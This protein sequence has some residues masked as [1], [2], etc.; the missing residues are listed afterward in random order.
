MLLKPPTP[1]LQVARYVL[2]GAC[3]PPVQLTLPLASLV[4]RALMGLLSRIELRR[5]YGTEI[6]EEAPLPRSRIFSGKDEDGHPLEGHLH[7]YYL[8]TDEDGD[9]LLDH[10]SVFTAQGFGPAEIRALQRLTLL[11]WRGNDERLPLMLTC[12]GCQSEVQA[13]PF[14]RSS[15]WVSTTPFVATRHAKVRGQKRDSSEVLGYENRP[16]FAELVLREEWHRL[17]AQRP[18]LPEI[19]EVQIMPA[20]S[21]EGSQGQRFV[22]TRSKDGDDGWRRAS[23]HFR[24]TFCEPVQGPLC[25]GH[26]S[27]FGLGLFLPERE[28][29]QRVN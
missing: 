21:A 6:P 5:L 24:I 10:I 7:A 4:R 23:A 18:G 27:H 17:C 8:P 3:P 11:N 26:S 2:G 13:P 28:A 1:T 15:V 29:S 12:L 22:L 25:L 14:A 16:R 20:P 19:A 9:G